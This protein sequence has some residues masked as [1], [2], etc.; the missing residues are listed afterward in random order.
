MAC[1]SVCIPLEFTART[2]L[3]TQDME[4]TLVEKHLHI[5]LDVDSGFET[6]VTVTPS[7]PILAEASSLCKVLHLIFHAVYLWN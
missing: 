1:I 5:C 4:K 3:H 2:L 7:E 6:A